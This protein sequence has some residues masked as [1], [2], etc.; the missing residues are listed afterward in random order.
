MYYPSSS[1][2]NRAGNFHVSRCLE[3]ILGIGK[4]LVRAYDFYRLSAFPGESMGQN[5][6]S[7]CQEQS[8]QVDQGI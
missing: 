3:K 2:G 4:D 6:Y 5:S 8:S 7:S 1:H